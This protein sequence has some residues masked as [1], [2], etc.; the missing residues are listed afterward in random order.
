MALATKCPHCGTVFKVA[1]DQLKLRGGIVR[2]GKCG[3]VFDGNASLVEPEA[4]TPAPAPAA[5]AEEVPVYTVDFD[6][7][8][9]AKPEPAAAPEPQPE[10]VPQPEPENAAEE[11]APQLH[12]DFD[13]NLTPPAQQPDADAVA[14]ATAIPA[15]AG[16][17]TERE[18]ADI[19]AVPDESAEPEA[20][21]ASAPEAE[22]E[23]EDAV[24][25]AQAGIHT[26]PAPDGEP[27]IVPEAFTLHE[28]EEP[29]VPDSESDGAELV[30]AAMAAETVHVT[31]PAPVE[32]EL[33]SEEPGFVTRV[34]KKEKTTR[35]LRVLMAVG[36][37]VLLAGLLAQGVISFGSILAARYPETKP[38][39][40]EACKL[41][42][43][44]VTL[45]A[46]IDTLSIETGELQTIGN[47]L[48]S[49][50]TTLRNSS[51]LVQAWP[52]I[53]LALT[54]TANKAVVRRVI[55]PQEYLPPRT[56]LRKGFAAHYEQPVK[57]YFQLKGV[58]A[59][60]YN[61][62]IFYP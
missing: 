33:E 59:S 29:S 2:C 30:P 18:A 25:P 9:I 45:P 40:T 48:F 58:S 31:E 13:L 53:E 14:D 3:E 24:I 5:P 8:F 46:Q 12:I 42:R 51:N 47:D 44:Q 43:C 56:D 16:I 41:L 38:A 57:V 54:D 17:H 27:S 26:E 52:H 55:A 34:R 19:A 61:I 39:L 22:P 62:A 4:T 37:I 32:D 15:Q 50:S 21:E 11:R 36:S 20:E 35:I 28:A 1:A 49:L 10:P 7:T 23:P 6:S 60:G